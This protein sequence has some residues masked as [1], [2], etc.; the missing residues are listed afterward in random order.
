M[1]TPAVVSDC[2]LARQL[3]GALLVSDLNECAGTQIGVVDVASDF[4][5]WCDCEA[6]D[7]DLRRRACLSLRR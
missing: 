2:A 5:V 3:R 1:V 4:H 6:E 7:A